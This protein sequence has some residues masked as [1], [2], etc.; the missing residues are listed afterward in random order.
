M[1]KPR[2]R[3]VLHLDLKNSKIC[4]IART[5]R[6]AAQKPTGRPPGSALVVE[7]QLDGQDFRGTQRRTAVKFT[8]AISFV[9]NCDTHKQEESIIF[10]EKQSSGERRIIRCGWLK[11]KFRFALQVVT[12]GLERDGSKTRTPRRAKRAMPAM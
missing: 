12:A 10:G 4:D 6:R 2:S 3:E 11:D 8:E 7:F 5:M 1:A 9:V